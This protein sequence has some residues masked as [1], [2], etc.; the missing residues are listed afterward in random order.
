MWELIAIREVENVEMTF[1]GGGGATRERL[2]S[3]NGRSMIARSYELG[4]F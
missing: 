4:Y 3:L 1:C 2:K